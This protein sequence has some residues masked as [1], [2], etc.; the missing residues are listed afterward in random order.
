MFGA[1]RTPIEV[2]RPC[3]FDAEQSLSTT[4]QAARKSTVSRKTQVSKNFAGLQA[5]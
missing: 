4:E 1:G 5:E 2:P 3:A